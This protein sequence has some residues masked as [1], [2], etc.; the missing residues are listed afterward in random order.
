MKKDTVLLEKR[1][2]NDFDHESIHM[3]AMPIGAP[4]AVATGSLIHQTGEVVSQT[5][6]QLFMRLEGMGILLLGG[7]LRENK[8]EHTIG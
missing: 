6:Q 1:W 3:E 7:Y 5:G 2:L 8:V 4:A